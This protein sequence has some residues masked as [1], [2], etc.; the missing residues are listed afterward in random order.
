VNYVAQKV[1]RNLLDAFIGIGNWSWENTRI[2]AAH[3]RNDGK[4]E[5][6]SLYNYGGN[7][8][9]L[10]AFDAGTKDLVRVWQSGQGNWSNWNWENTRICAADVR[11]N[12]RSEL[13]GLYNYDNN[14]TALFVFDAD[15]KDWVRVWRSGQGNWNWENT[16]IC[17]PDVRNNGKSESGEPHEFFDHTGRSRRGSP[18]IP[19]NFVST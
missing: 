19:I 6:C 12:G 2:C 18:P 7:V 4:S 11:N 1:T 15:T 16:R 13:C 9:A 14:D 5:L 10:F 3:V 8:T 17:A